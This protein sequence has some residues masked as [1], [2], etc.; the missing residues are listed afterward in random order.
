VGWFSGCVEY[1]NEIYAY[2]CQAKYVYV[3]EVGG[4]VVSVCPAANVA[5]PVEEVWELLEQPS[6]YDRWWDAHFVRSVP[7]GPAIPGQ[8]S[9]ATTEALGRLWDVTFVVKDILPDR[10][11][12]QLDATLP[13]GVIDH[14]TIMCTP[15]D[16]VSCRLQFG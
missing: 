3:M 1:R 4:M 2:S 16:A 15:V 9:Y 12:I 8:I 6:N 5:A 10:H 14:A 13:F 11:R 7:E